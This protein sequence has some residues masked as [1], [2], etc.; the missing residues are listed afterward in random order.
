MKLAM[1][2]MSLIRLNKYI[3]EA[4]ICSRRKADE[5]IVSGRISVNSE[6]I[7]ELGF[8]INPEKDIVALDGEK[9]HNEKKVYFVLNKPAGYISTSSDEKGR[10]KVIDLIK[11]KQRIFSVG[12]LDRDTTGVLIL[13]NDGEF[14]NLLTHPKNEVLRE[15]LVTVDKNIDFEKL[16]KIKVIELEDGPVNIIS[17]RET[18]SPNEVIIKLNE[19]R[20]H[21]VKRLFNRLGF[22]VKKL[23]RI[24]FAGITAA[25]L[26]FGNFRKLSYIEVLNI[27]N[28]YK[29]N[30]NL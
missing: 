30:E 20:N 7:T 16:R 11:V 5:L 9:I 28:K 17:I 14:A 18:K 29:K 6:I 12:R 3:S 15:Y 26:E 23:H 27:K 25:G 8:K 22:R 21:I 1:K 10:K 13:T 4:G 19:G 24:S 2:Q